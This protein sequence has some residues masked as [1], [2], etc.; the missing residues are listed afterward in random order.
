MAQK[1]LT[2][3]DKAYEILLNYEGDNPYILKLKSD[4]K[5]WGAMDKMSDFNIDFVLGNHDREIVNVNKI[6]HIAKWSALEIKKKY[7]FD[8]M[9]DKAYVYS[10]I[11]ETDRYYCCIVK[12]TRSMN[13]VVTFLHKMSVLTDMFSTDYHNY[14]VD[15]SRYNRLSMEKD[16][17]RKLRS[18]QED[19]VKFLLSRKKCILALEQ[20]LG[21]SSVLSVAAI[22]GNFDSVII[23]CPA[24][25]KTNW[26]KELEWYVPERD[27]TIVDSPTGKKKNELEEFLG[28]PIGKSGK[29]VSELLDEAKKKGKWVDNRFV[30][31]NFDILDEF[32]KPTRSKKEDAIKEYAENNPLL[33]YIY[34]RKS[35]IIIDEAHRLSNSTS[36]RYKVISDLIKKGK[37]DSV[38][39]STG[40]PVTNAPENLYCLLRLIDCPVASDYQMYANVY[41][42]AERIYMKGEFSK[43]SER[44]LMR[45]GK[46]SWSQMTDKEKDKCRE[47]IDTHAR[48]VMIYKKATN[49]DELKEAISHIYLRMLKDEV[50]DLPNKN[51]HELKYPL[52]PKEKDEYNLLWEQYEAEKLS[53]DPTKELNKELIEGGIYRGY[54]AE[55]MVSRTIELVDKLISKGEKVIIAC[56]FDNEVS[57]LKE[58][59]GDKSV[60]YNGKLNLKQKDAAVNKF[61]NDDSV[62][63]YIG[64]IIA[65][66][67]GLT[68]TNSHNLVFNSFDYTYANNAQMED[69]IHRIGQTKECDIYYQMFEDTH[70]EH[71]WDIVLR[72]QTLSEKLIVA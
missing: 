49:V 62:M 6:I 47:Y 30:I 17:N 1:K 14:N 71:M 32:Y 3:A 67:V 4:A 16:P 45:I 29:K 55:R 61:K 5:T 23:I 48:K 39:L 34:N 18:Y 56:C 20:G 35:L 26:K 58:Y 24:S 9:P 40:T 54:L 19:A 50:A 64:N 11:G 59:Y 7:N 65:A 13:P 15:F 53:E 33:K 41:C 44:Y 12:Y 66:G 70:C 63:V 46:E 60:I 69:R 27:I 51:I 72:K 43:W 42:G 57:M 25:L 8:F 38:Y 28:Y 22:E 36:T 31:V 10:V 21:K 68:L 52:T 37:P 2:K